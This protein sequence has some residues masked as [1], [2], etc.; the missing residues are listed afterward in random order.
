M[1]KTDFLYER[2]RDE[3]L[4]QLER[5]VV[6][7][8]RGWDFNTTPRNYDSGRVYGGINMFILSM[9][10]KPSPFWITFKS[11]QK[12][13]ARLKKGAESVPVL[14]WK[15][16]DKVEER[17][18]GTK[19]ITQYPVLFYY[20]VFNV[21]DVEGLPEKEAKDCKRIR[22]ADEIV[23]GYKNRPLI[24]HGDYRPCYDPIRDEI[25]LPSPRHYESMD[26]Y[27]ST[28]FHELTH[29]TGAAHRLNRDFKGVIKGEAYAMEELIAE[30]GA[31]FLCAYTGIDNTREA[32]AAYIDGWKKA[33]K[34][35][36]VKCLVTA[37]QRAKK[38]ADYI[39]GETYAEA[40]A[41]VAEPAPAPAT[42]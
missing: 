42:A 40:G 39:L 7:W 8:Q 20:R 16:F 33:I 38:A 9:I 11:I 6:P 18:D 10:P 24:N 13:G 34:G 15:W 31:A 2:V 28:L 29:S 41:G 19:E 22:G 21:A 1:A 17:E 37:A 25:Y 30:F 35:A 3:I 14:Y 4:A 32:N 27:Y 12:H 26:R 5:G 23:E 36:D